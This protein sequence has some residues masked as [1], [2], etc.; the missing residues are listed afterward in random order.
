MTT[1]M[2]FISYTQNANLTTVRTGD[3]VSAL[4]YTPIQERKLLS[5]LSRRGLIVRVRRGLY[6]VPSKIPFGGKWAPGEYL[7]LKTLI[8]DR[9][10]SYQIT[11]PNAFYRYGWNDQIPSR[12][13]VYND[14]ISGDRQIGA[15]QLTLIKVDSSRL[16][17]VDTFRTPEGIEV[18]ISS[19]SRALMD[20]VY[21]WSRFN[22]LPMAYDWIRKE[23]S[24][25]D[26]L[27]ATL[28]EVC[29]QFG[30][31][32]TLRRIGR[33]LAEK[34]VSEHLLRKIEKD[35]NPSNSYIPLIPTLP[36]RGGVDQRWGVVINRA[37]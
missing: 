37:Q 33:I 21:D 6:L 4:G 13:Y 32:S 15:T 14:R 28:V 36:K 17:G 26:S 5:R 29:R 30:N 11:G 20:A 3:L 8:D 25:D 18:V 31:Q 23:L 35:L 12:V 34:Q 22:S 2:Q 7:A 27:A 19:K 10:G 16:G 24:T 9:Q 1:D